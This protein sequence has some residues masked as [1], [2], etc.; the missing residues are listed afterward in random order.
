METFTLMQDIDEWDQSARQETSCS[1]RTFDRLPT[2]QDWQPA[3]HI[4]TAE[5]PKLLENNQ[6][7]K[8]GE[9]QERTLKI[10]NKLKMCLHKLYLT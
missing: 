5:A 8:H 6:H 4:A 9:A 3:R 7:N 1:N 10:V 2:C